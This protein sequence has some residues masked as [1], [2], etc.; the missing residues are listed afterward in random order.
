MDAIISIECFYGAGAAYGYRP[1]TG[2][3]A[4]RARGQLQPGGAR[5]RHH[6]AHDQR[7]DRRP[8]AHA[9]RPVVHARRAQS[10]PD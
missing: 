1:V 9:G 8:G 2:F 6:P 5:P 7:A 4:D 10:H 3:R